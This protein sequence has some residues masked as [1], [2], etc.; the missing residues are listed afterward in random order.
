MAKKDNDSSLVVRQK[1]D[2]ARTDDYDAQ[3]ELAREVMARQARAYGS[4]GIS[5]PDSY[6]MKFEIVKHADG[7]ITASPRT[8]PFKNVPEERSG[9]SLMIRSPFSDRMGLDGEKRGKYNDSDR[10]LFNE[11]GTV[12]VG[13]VA[14][15]GSVG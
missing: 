5:D 14:A 7:T 15:V 12:E 4:K 1:T 10:L 11:Y 2:V 6:A 9:M 3:V 8:K 13:E